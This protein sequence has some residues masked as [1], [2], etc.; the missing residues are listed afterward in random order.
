MVNIRCMWGCINGRQLYNTNHYGQWASGY[1]DMCIQPV[2]H[3]QTGLDNW[4]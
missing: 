3:C 1:F 4:K 2:S